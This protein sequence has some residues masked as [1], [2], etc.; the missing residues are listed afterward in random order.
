META[1]GHGGPHRCLV[2]DLGAGSGR[3]I[4]AELTGGGLSLTE[5]HR[6]DGLERRGPEGPEW[7]MTRILAE[8]ET[9]LAR[10]AAAGGV[11]SVAVDS[12]GVDYGLIDAEGRL[13]PPV[14]TYRHPR[15]QRGFDRCPVPKPRIAAIAGAQVI[16]INTI[17][18]LA[19][20]VVTEPE[21]LGRAAAALMIAPLV[22]HHLSG[23]GANETTLARTSG[24][25]DLAAGDWSAE[26]AGGIGLAPGLLAPLVAPATLLGPLRPGLAAASGLG[27][28]PV[29]AVASH[30]TASAV[31]AL[32]PGP[33]EAF[34]IAGS[35]NLLGYE[36]PEAVLAPEASAAGYGSE[37]GAFGRRTV[38]RSLS[39]LHLMRRL[40]TAWAARTGED[41]DFARLDA[42]AAEAGPEGPAIDVADP[43]FFDPPDMIAAMEAHAPAL[44]TLPGDRL[45]ALAAA[46]YRGLAT[47]IAAHVATI[48]RLRGRPVSALRLGGGGARDATLCAGLARALG[49]PVIAGPVEAS[50]AGNAVVQFLAQGALASLAEGQARIAAAGEL[51]RFDPTH[52]TASEGNPT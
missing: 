45:G 12:W 24:L 18:Q 51:R 19:D 16:A 39:G 2:F 52:A 25:H 49:R 37:G 6:F 40:R 13:L 36:T 17:F 35:W 21:T 29:V 33:D 7:D 15:S 5:L 34:L 27:P 50:A 47:D 43:A 9:G 14:R 20:Q 44:A 38:I 10:A 32:A 22:S 48:E 42:R 28:V 1:A 11:G 30:D 3:A 46:I 31:L 4:L 26:L 8:V 41:V 23:V